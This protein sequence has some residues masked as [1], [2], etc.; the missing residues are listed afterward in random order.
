MLLTVTM[1]PV[2]G[3]VS[4]AFR[5]GTSVALLTM[6]LRPMSRGPASRRRHVDATS[7]RSR[8]ARLGCCMGTSAGA[9]T[10]PVVLRASG[11][12]RTYGGFMA[13]P[14][15]TPD[16]ERWAPSA[17]ALP[18]VDGVKTSVPLT[19]LLDEAARPTRSRAGNLD[20]P[21]ARVLRRV[22][23]GA[24]GRQRL[25]AVGGA[26]LARVDRSTAALAL[27]HTALVGSARELPAL[28]GAR[29]GRRARGLWRW[30]GL[31]GLRLGRAAGR[32]EEPEGENRMRAHGDE[33]TI[34]Q[35]ARRGS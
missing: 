18:P 9:R 4:R 23:F 31:G 10:T 6:V 30:L 19:I 13:M 5:R 26:E 15:A 14:L 35:T 7:T 34:E 27:D 1:S 17:R 33:G 16:L 11:L 28:D 22:R 20:E 32:D 21:P 3:P 24:P 2:R 29:F 12:S 8:R 25:A